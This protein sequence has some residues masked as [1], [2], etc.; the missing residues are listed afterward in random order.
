MI[1]AAMKAKSDGS[2]DAA[3]NAV[4]ARDARWDGVVFYAVSTTGVFCRPSCPSRRPRRENVRLFATVSEAQTAGFRPCARCRPTQAESESGDH[5]TALRVCRL[6]ESA[7]DK[8]PTLD[9]L[10][11]EIGL[12]P[13]HLQ[14]VFKRALGVSPKQ[15]ERAM[16]Y[17]RFRRE[18]PDGD[19]TGA[20]YDAGFGAASRFYTDAGRYLGM[21]PKS[22]AARGRGEE[23]RYR[24]RE[25]ALGHLLVAA[26]AR[27]LCAVRFGDRRRELVANFQEAYVRATIAEGGE[28]VD[29]A[30]QALVEFVDGRAPWPELPVDV[31][32]T[33]FQ[34]RVWEALRRI[35]PGETLTYG[36][37][38]EAL[39]TPRGARAVA[40]ACADNPVAL[41]IPCHRI[42][43]KAGG[44]G[45]YLYGPARKEKLLRNES[46]APQKR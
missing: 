40:R 44:V 39:G 24:V 5:A 45:G 10:A 6:I 14:R 43:P 12:S 34:A 26:T 16:R 11:G 9:A 1:Q 23:I 36:A 20:M 31:R 25:T 28:L 8:P 27:G 21:A 18:A 37:L 15:Y 13:T 17:E 4:L 35:P 3:W 38:A 22:V 33:A 41:A 30:A 19:V 2:R 7:D 46:H 42:V 32:A 29:G